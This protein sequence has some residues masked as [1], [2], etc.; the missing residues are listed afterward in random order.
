MHW[1]L[2]VHV[3]PRPSLP[4]HVP[5]GRPAQKFPFA[6]SPSPPQVVRQAVA[7]LH[8]NAPQLV[9]VVCAHAPPLQVPATVSVALPTGHDAGAHV[10]PAA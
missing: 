7:P 6:Q 1:S 9:V 10:V 8:M 4:V 5:T 2:A 3:A